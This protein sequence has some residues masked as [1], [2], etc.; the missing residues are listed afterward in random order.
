MKRKNHGANIMPNEIGQ[1]KRP[2]VHDST[3]I[4]H[5]K[6]RR[7]KE[8]CSWGQGEEGR[9]TADACGIPL[10]G[11]DRVLGLQR[12]W[13]YVYMS[14]LKTTGAGLSKGGLYGR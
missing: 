8:E 11:A 10:G 13:L 1:H 2:Q 4:K 7:Q 9:A 3:P 5:L 12:G 6:R 14:I